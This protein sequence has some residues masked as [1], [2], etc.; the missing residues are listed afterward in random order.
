MQLRE[1]VRR[2]SF[3]RICRALLFLQLAL[4]AARRYRFFRALRE[5]NQKDFGPAAVLESRQEI[6]EKEI[7]SFCVF[8][9]TTG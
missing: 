1:Q 4:A 5:S 6:E 9:C 3:P 2:R 7:F 8:A